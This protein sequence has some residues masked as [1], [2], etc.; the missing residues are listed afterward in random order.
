MS[1]RYTRLFALPG[2]LCSHSAPAAILAGALLKD[3]ETGE[4]LAQLKLKNVQ[5]KPIQALTVS[6]RRWTPRACPWDSRR[7]ISIWIWASLVMVNLARKKPL[8][9]PT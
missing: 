9:F 5:A 4:I 3:N 2:C 6:L 1:Q 7:N 8:F